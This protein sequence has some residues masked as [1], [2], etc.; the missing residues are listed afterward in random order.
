MNIGL[1]ALGF[2]VLC[3]VACL[4][5][6]PRQEEK[7]KPLCGKYPKFDTQIIDL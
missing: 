7:K 2:A 3:G 1:L 5:L 6:A 4:I